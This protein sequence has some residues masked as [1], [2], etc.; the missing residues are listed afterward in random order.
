MWPLLMVPS[1]S[2][3]VKSDLRLRLV[4]AAIVFIY[5]PLFWRYV[6]PF[7]SGSHTTTFLDLSAYSDDKSY[8]AFIS[9]A[10]VYTPVYL[11]A[12]LDDVLWSMYK[13][14]GNPLFPPSP[15]GGM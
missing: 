1:M 6:F 10:F 2:W 15:V 8:V 12:C 9:V 11:I 7:V 5:S 4:K 13:I 14:F 3:S